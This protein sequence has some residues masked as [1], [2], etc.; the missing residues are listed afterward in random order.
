MD[1][2]HGTQ[3]VWGQDAVAVNGAID[4]ATDSVV[5]R[6][7]RQ[8]LDVI[9]DVAD[10]F[11]PLDHVS[12]VGLE[13]RARDLAEQGHSAV[14]VNFIGQVIEHAVVRKHHKFV[15]NFLD[16]AI[17]ALLWESATSWGVVLGGG[18]G[19]RHHREHQR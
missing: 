19:E 4:G 2:R 12:G 11:N 5:V 18:T 1:G 16:D 15:M 3:L 9:D 10:A 7:E 8:D 17:D 6:R 13:R 14:G